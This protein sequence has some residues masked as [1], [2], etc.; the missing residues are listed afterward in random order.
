MHENPLIEKEILTVTSTLPVQYSIGDLDKA[1]KK[2]STQKIKE[3][4]KI[5]ENVKQLTMIE[6]EEID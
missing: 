4:E 5:H 6:S 3:L 1:C 2:F